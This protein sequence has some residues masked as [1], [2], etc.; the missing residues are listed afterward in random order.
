MYQED[1]IAKFWSRVIIAGPDDCWIWRGG[2]RPNGY[3]ILKIAGKTHGAHR[4]AYELAHGVIPHA[5]TG[6][7]IESIV[8]MHACDTKKCVNPNH[9]SLGTTLDNI[10][11][12]DTKGRSARG[13]AHYR[14][15]LTEEAVEAIRKG[16]SN[17]I[18]RPVLAERFSVSVTTIS[19]ITNGENWKHIPN[20][21]PDRPTYGSGNPNAKLAEHHI[22]AIR[23]RGREGA[24]NPT[25]ARE[26]GVSPETIRRIIN[27]KRWRHVA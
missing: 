27:E 22:P 6:R 10:R 19:R 5:G 4:I 13:A 15:K 20:S 2:C 21:H 7:S 17:G 3:G 9:L 8:V 11:D 14:A 12:R 18:P 24:S 23:A 16:R 25:I 26:F 1:V